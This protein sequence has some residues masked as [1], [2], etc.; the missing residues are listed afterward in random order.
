MIGHAHSPLRLSIPACE[1]WAAAKQ[2]L[3]G[4]TY[5]CGALPVP[6]KRVR[7]APRPVYASAQ[8]R[9]FRYVA[10]CGHERLRGSYNGPHL[11]WPWPRRPAGPH[12]D[13]GG[14][15]APIDERQQCR[16]WAQKRVVEEK[17]GEVG[18]K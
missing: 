7:F 17:K 11:H 6:A 15:P 4:D 10:V 2:R 12:G 18:V 3:S 9:A 16:G 8:A 5:P 1:W 14:G 13:G